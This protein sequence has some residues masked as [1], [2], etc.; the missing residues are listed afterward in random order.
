MFDWLIEWL[1]IS[2][3][4]W[5]HGLSQYLLQNFIYRR[6]TKVHVL[7]TLHEFWLRRGPQ[8]QYNITRSHQASSPGLFS[9]KCLLRSHWTGQGNGE[10]S[11]SSSIISTKYM[12]SVL[13]EYLLYLLILCRG[14]IPSHGV[15]CL[16]EFSVKVL[17]SSFKNESKH[18]E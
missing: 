7:C 16:L 15:Q 12:H 11:Y 9:T 6:M 1:I 8:S 13:Q 2:W 3:Q 14:T 5:P 4:T 18:S 10:K 17:C